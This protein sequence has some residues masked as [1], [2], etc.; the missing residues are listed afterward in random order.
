M[1]F[2]DHSRFG[3]SMRDRSIFLALEMTFFLGI[4][5]LNPFF[6][7]FF[8]W[9]VPAREATLISG[10]GFLSRMLQHVFLDIISLDAWLVALVTTETPLPLMCWHVLF[11]VTPLCEGRGT[12]GCIERAFPRNEWACAFWEYVPLWRNICTL[13]NCKAFLQSGFACGFACGF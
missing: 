1:G 9:I 10:K 5:C 3:F 2:W 13:C 7:G 8:W 12:N 6:K 11:E 4:C